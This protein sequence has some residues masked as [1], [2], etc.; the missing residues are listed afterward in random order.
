MIPVRWEQQSVII[1]LRSVQLNTF[2]DVKMRFTIYPS[3]WQYRTTAHHYSTPPLSQLPFCSS[4]TYSLIQSTMFKVRPMKSKDNPYWLSYVDLNRSTPNLSSLRQSAVTVERSPSRLSAGEFKHQRRISTG[5]NL[6]TYIIFIV[7][8]TITKVCPIIK[9]EARL[10]SRDDITLGFCLR[11][12]ALLLLF[13]LKDSTQIHFLFNKRGSRT[14]ITTSSSHGK[15]IPLVTISHSL[16]SLQS[17]IIFLNFV[18]N[19]LR[20]DQYFYI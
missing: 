17:T 14:S 6:N 19:F 3:P 1:P 20:M 2:D 7:S 13:F 9:I 12:F 16:L 5:G 4:R 11:K 15:L 8:N 18:V 10:I